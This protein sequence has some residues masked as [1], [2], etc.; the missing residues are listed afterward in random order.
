M[1]GD[2][3]YDRREFAFVKPD[4]EADQI[5]SETFGQQQDKSVSALWQYR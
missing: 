4:Q 1:V 3:R 5:K 2:A